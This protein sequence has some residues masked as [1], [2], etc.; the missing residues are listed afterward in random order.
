[1]SALPLP[2]SLPVTRTTPLP[3]PEAAGENEA[4]IW[5]RLHPKA[6]LK[7]FLDQSVR[8]DGR[9]LTEPRPSQV[10]CG[11]ISTSDSSA[12]V[13][14][15]ETSLIV[16][17]KA[18]IGAPLHAL[19]KQGMLVIDAHL[20]PHVSPSNPHFTFGAPSLFS[21]TIT[22]HCHSL[23]VDSGCLELESLCV[24]ENVSVWY[25][26]IDITLLSFDGNIYD[27]AIL[28]VMQSLHSLSLP[29]TVKNPQIKGRL[30]VDD[31][32]LTPLKLS[33]YLFCL[34]FVLLGDTIVCDPTA[35]EESVS[36]ATLR[37]T[38]NH[39]GML[40]DVWKDGGVW[41][42]I[43]EIQSAIA[44]TQQH[45]KQFFVNCDWTTTPRSA[46]MITSAGARQ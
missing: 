5:S 17:V 18:E 33:C 27:A 19:P 22:D 35:E 38:V 37:V 3:A 24:E 46:T 32:Q 23:V 30:L 31:R 25:L 45:A 13:Q 15:G 44:L 43:D 20:L 12:I 6:Y 41:I 8:P 11:D 36:D 1:M 2:S 26:Y 21:T 16:S 42:S 29:L 4:Q 39:R 9:A 7:K 14:L 28:G 40:V 10:S 34:S